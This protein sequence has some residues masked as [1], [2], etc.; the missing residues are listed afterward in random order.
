MSATDTIREFARI[1]ATAGLT[2]DEI[3]LMENKATLLVEQIATLERDKAA[4]SQENTALLRENGNLKLEID[5]LKNQLQ[6]VRSNE[7][8]RIFKYIFEKGKQFSEPEIA[9][10]FQITVSAAAYHIDSLLRE[11]LIQQAT[12]ASGAFEDTGGD[13]SAKYEITSDGLTYIVKNGLN[14]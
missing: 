10:H 9:K 1:A 13:V 7:T 2:K 8:L 4:L 12:M 3:D 11:K 5:N 6:S 14:S